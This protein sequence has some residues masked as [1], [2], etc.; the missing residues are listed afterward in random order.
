MYL[1][2][3]VLAMLPL[4]AIFLGRRI[5]HIETEEAKV[6]I[7]GMSI[8]SNVTRVAL[9]L[10]KQQMSGQAKDWDMRK[11]WAVWM[12]L[13]RDFWQCPI[14]SNILGPKNITHRDRGGKGAN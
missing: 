3:A 8:L 6:Q 5:L 10:L 13:P 7:K 2:R 11:S 9:P 12:Y 14:A 4:P 1:P